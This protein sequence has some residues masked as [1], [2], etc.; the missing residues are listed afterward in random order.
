M[1]LVRTTFCC[2]CYC[3][4]LGSRRVCWLLAEGDKIF[5]QSQLA[6][7]C[8][9]IKILLRVQC[10]EISMKAA[11]NCLL[12]QGGSRAVPSLRLSVGLGKMTSVGAYRATTSPEAFNPCLIGCGLLYK[13][14]HSKHAYTDHSL[15]QFFHLHIAS[16]VASHATKRRMR[17]VHSLPRRKGMLYAYLI[18][19]MALT[20]TVRY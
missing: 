8:Y 6:L 9:A 17:Y 15:R 14:F 18:I 1:Q 12:L 13:N 20:R 2:C 16:I 10:V 19:Q 7:Q 4:R 11:M 3:S 5:M